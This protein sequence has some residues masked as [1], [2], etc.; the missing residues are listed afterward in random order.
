MKI[1]ALI[2]RV[3][4]GGV[5]IYSGWQKLMSP[6]EE[7]RAVI[8]QYAFLPK[9][10]IPWAAFLVPWLEL[11]FGTFLLLGF[12]ARKSAAVLGY[13]LAVF[14]GLLVRSLW[15]HLEIAECGCFGSG[16]LLAPKDALLLDACLFLIAWALFRR[17]NHY[18]SLDELLNR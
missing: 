16:F 5:F 18:L 13:F 4:L 11:I 3:I 12:M 7:F 17:K 1:V 10:V 15:L 14:I 9:P 2:F 6:I 8:V